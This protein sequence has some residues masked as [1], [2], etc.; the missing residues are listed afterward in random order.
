MDL[1]RLLHSYVTRSLQIEASNNTLYVRIKPGAQSEQVYN[2]HLS[3]HS[4]P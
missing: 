1:Y 2:L 4:H 3:D